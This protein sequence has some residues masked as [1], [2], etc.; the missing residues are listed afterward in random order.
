[1]PSRSARRKRRHR[2]IPPNCV[3]RRPPSRGSLSPTPPQLYSDPLSPATNPEGPTPLDFF[4][5][6]DPTDNP[7]GL[8]LQY[9]RV[10][11]A[12]TLKCYQR[13]YFCKPTMTTP[14][15]SSAFSHDTASQAGSSQQPPDHND[16]TLQLSSSP[17]GSPRSITWPTRTNPTSKKGHIPASVEASLEAKLSIL[18]RAPSIS[19]PPSRPP[20]HVPQPPPLPC[21]RKKA[22]QNRRARFC[23]PASPVPPP[24]LYS[25]PPSPLPPATKSNL[26]KK[27][28]TGFRPSVVNGQSLTPVPPPTPPPTPASP[29][30]PTTTLEHSKKIFSRKPAV[31]RP[32]WLADKTE[33]ISLPPLHT[34][35]FPTNKITCKTPPTSYA[36]MVPSHTSSQIMVHTSNFITVTQNQHCMEGSSFAIP[37]TLHCTAPTFR[38]T[39]PIIQ[40]PLPILPST[41]PIFGSATSSVHPSVPPQQEQPLTFITEYHLTSPLPPQEEDAAVL[42]TPTS[43]PK[44]RLLPRRHPQQAWGRPLSPLG[45]PSTPLPQ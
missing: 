39:I 44:P 24:L 23:L 27:S 7:S 6:S 30:P 5:I 10:P 42:T 15:A 43:P 19:R 29:M 12:S 22:T 33:E 37:G 35:D 4:R 2:K 13:D 31:Q 9:Y 16:G 41:T 14:R 21:P 3:L 11:G 17:V 36:H 38:S 18:P 45:R 8:P 34:T 26:K 32:P 25:P 40:N 28:A 1:M 20:S